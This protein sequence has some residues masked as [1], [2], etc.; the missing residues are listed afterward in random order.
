MM[1]GD[2]G[3]KVPPLSDGIH[4]FAPGLKFNGAM[5]TLADAFN[6]AN[7]FDTMDCF[8]WYDQYASTDT[9]HSDVILKPIIDRFQ[10]LFDEGVIQLSDFS[11]QPAYRSATM[12]KTRTTAMTIKPSEQWNI[13]QKRATDEFA[14]MPFTA[15][16]SQL[17]TMSSALR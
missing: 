17:S 10:F 5:L 3:R 8:D 14:L 4:A 13:Q 16:T 1:F 7:F 6:E 11:L 15:A 2:S 12:Y 9:G